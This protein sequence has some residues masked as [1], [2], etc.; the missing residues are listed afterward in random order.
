MDDSRQVRHDEE[1]DRDQAGGHGE[2]GQ[3]NPQFSAER[4]VF[5]GGR[6]LFHGFLN[7]R[8]HYKTPLSADCK[9]PYCQAAVLQVSRLQTFLALRS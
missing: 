7:G 2:A 6:F 3:P 9:E 4:V 1:E 8:L 5:S